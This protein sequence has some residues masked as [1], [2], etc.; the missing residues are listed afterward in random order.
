[1]S[2]WNILLFYYKNAIV[3]G[4]LSYICYL[5]LYI[6]YISVQ[7]ILC[8]VFLL[9]VFVLCALCCQFLY[10]VHF[11]FIVLGILQRLFICVYWYQL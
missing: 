6:A 5:C 3:G 2:A 4:L 8:C 1:M 9:F 11:F 7:Q 10:I